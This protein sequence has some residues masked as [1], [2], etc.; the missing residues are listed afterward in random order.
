VKFISL[1]LSLSLS[2]CLSLS[3][4]LSLSVSVSSGYA[5]LTVNVFQKIKKEMFF[6]K[7]SMCLLHKKKKTF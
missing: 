7:S 2:L 5:L 3:L 4:S 6:K 1:S